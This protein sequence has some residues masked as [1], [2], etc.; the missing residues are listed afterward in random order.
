M[1][2]RSTSSMDERGRGSRARL[3]RAARAVALLGA[4][5]GALAF[6]GHMLGVPVLATYFPG[7]P[8]TQPLAGFALILAGLAAAFRARPDASIALRLISFGMGAMVFLAGLMVS[9]E[10][11]MNLDL[12]V[13]AW[14]PVHVDDGDPHPGRPSPLTAIAA[15]FLGAAIMLFDVRLSRNVYPREWFSVGALLFVFIAMVGYLFGASELYEFDPYPLRGVPVPASIGIALVA[16]S[17]LVARPG[18]GFMRIVT[19][20]GPGGVLMRRLGV[21][22]IVA[23]PFF[24]AALLVVVELVGLI[25]VALILG[26][27]TVAS[28]A[29]ALLLVG[30]TAVPLERAHDAEI[31]SRKRVEELLTYAPLGVFVCDLEGR[32]IEVNAAA[33]RLIGYSREEV[34][35]RNIADFIPEEDIPRLWRAR[36]RQIAG[37]IDVGAWRMVRKD[38]S[39]VPLEVTAKVLPDGRWQGFAA[40]ITRRLEL[41]KKLRASLVEQV[42]LA[43]AGVELAACLELEETLGCI[44]RLG[45]EELGDLCAVDFL[46]GDVVRRLSFASRAELDEET[47]VS[48]SRCEVR[49]DA[50][51]PVSSVLDTKKGVIVSEVDEALIELLGSTPEQLSALRCV[52]L[53]TAMLVPMIARGELIGILCVASC[54]PDRTYGP[55]DL[56]LAEEL[57][58]RAGLAFDNVRLYHQSRRQAAMI[59]NL[60]EG[61]L[62]IRVSDRRIVYTNARFD[63]MLGYERGELLGEPVHRINAQI[64][65]DP[66]ERAAEIIE[67]LERTG[68]WHGEVL[69]LRKDGTPVWHS[70][71]VSTYPHEEHGPV[72]MAAHTE[73]DERKKL[74][75]EA[76]RGLREKEVLL[77][78]IHHRVKNNLQVISS[79]FSLQ[80][81]RTKSEEVRA[82]LDESRMRV[83]SIALVHEQLYRST[84]LAGVDFDEYLRGL[85]AAIRTSYAAETIAMSSSAAGVVLD[86]EAA[87]PCALIIAELVSNS[88]KHAFRGGRGNV[89]VTAHLDE[90]DCVLEVADDGVGIPRDFDWTRTRSLGL[91]LVRDLAKQLR[92]TVEL[93][94]AHGS[95]FILRFPLRSAVHGSR[96]ADDEAPPPM[97]PA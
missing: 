76:A 67:E 65:V 61:V 91:R 2:R 84:D 5:I 46:E 56:R 40:D 71:S 88:L 22:A 16:V 29:L 20:G 37:E 9:L 94:R 33:C 35:G 27:G 82:I 68:M 97:S 39:L 53:H 34:L 41:E 93:D 57:A 87:V 63:E 1:R 70:A 75:E 66:E 69:N 19:S 23:V 50:D 11:A 80:R 58:L 78:E 62:L 3:E 55:T 47:H 73:I 81:S 89:V 54:D 72:W 42:F 44:V 43:H 12:W 90:G 77:K 96:A 15:L 74:E 25:D 92:G 60:A 26:I 7:K 51:H 14:F 4:V 21:M 49:M 8:T 30:M 10:Y 59:T 48:L 31:A 83:Q 95:R 13:D 6:A 36:D 18:V 52:R 64:E 85:L 79:L 45:I 38:G 24:G 17:T 28:V 86:V 32:Y